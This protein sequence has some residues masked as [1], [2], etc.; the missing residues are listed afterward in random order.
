[1]IEFIVVWYVIGLISTVAA[2]TFAWFADPT[3]PDRVTIGEGFTVGDIVMIPV[4]SALGPLMVI[5]LIRE[6]LKSI[7]GSGFFNYVVVRKKRK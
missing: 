3:G 1:V 4:L 7:S 5:L 6:I 2:M